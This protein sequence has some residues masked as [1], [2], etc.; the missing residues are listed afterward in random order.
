[1]KVGKLL[2]Y[3]FIGWVFFIALQGCGA[4]PYACMAVE[5]TGDSAFVNRPV[6]LNAYCS[7]SADEYYWEINGDSVY[8]TPRITLTFTHTGVQDI[9]LLV[10]N[11]TKSAGATKK[12]MVYP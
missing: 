4:R 1:M 2:P 11:G 9:Y 12:L 7:S 5:S 3:L 10:T 6:S 8:F